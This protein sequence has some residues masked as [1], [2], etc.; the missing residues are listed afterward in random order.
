MSRLS[1]I[2]LLVLAVLGTAVTGAYAW[3]IAADDPHASLETRELAPDWWLRGE[4]EE[5]HA[6]GRDGATAAPGFHTGQFRRFTHG[7]DP[8]LEPWRCGKC[9]T[10]A[11]CK[12]C[13]AT[14]PPS[15]TPGFRRPGEGLDA[16]RHA[17]LGRLRPS[18]CMTCHR[19]FAESCGE[20]HTANEL[21][22]WSLDARRELQRWPEFLPEE[23]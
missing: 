10:T 23:P 3:W 14:A 12:D 17:M 11:G 4:C 18:S 6:P 19:S 2:V 9:H 13:H 21:A 5:C 15:H 22:D 7:R 1:R 8:G 16:R 20:C